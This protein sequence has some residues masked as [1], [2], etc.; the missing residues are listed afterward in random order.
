MDNIIPWSDDLEAHS[1]EDSNCAYDTTT[2]YW[3]I[4]KDFI[5]NAKRVEHYLNWCGYVYIPS[6]HPCF[7]GLDDHDI[8]VHGGITYTA[9]LI[10]EGEDYLV[11]GFDCAH[12]DDIVPVA[13]F[14]G[15][16]ATYK[17]YNFVR[18][19]LMNLADRLFAIQP[20]IQYH[21]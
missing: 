1:V 7:N 20:V 21:G 12:Y 14:N 17:N 18:E 10:F 13:G 15:H 11:V 19:E 3:F 6:V 2:P 16:H 8:N 4:H 5:C 9:P